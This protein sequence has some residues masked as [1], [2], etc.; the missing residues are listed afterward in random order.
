[1]NFNW[2]I[3]DFR[4][5]T[6]AWKFYLGDLDYMMVIT[7][8]WSLVEGTTRTSSDAALCRTRCC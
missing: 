5:P 8:Y 2:G 4:D 7:D 1:M 3:F 6:F